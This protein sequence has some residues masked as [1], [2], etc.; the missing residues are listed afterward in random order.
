SR[1]IEWGERAIEL[2]CRLGNDEILAHALNNVG[3]ARTR[4]TG[5]AGWLEL[6]RS[7]Q[8]ALRCRFQEHVARAHTNLASF[9]IDNRDYRAGLPHLEAGLAFCSEYG[10]SVAEG[11]LRALRARLNFEQGAWSEAIEQAEQVLRRG[12]LSVAARISALTVVGRVRTRRGVDGALEPLGEAWALAMGAGE[13]RGIVTVAAARAEHGWLHGDY[14]SVADELRS[15]VE[16]ALRDP[17]H[18]R[19]GEF[20]FWACRARA[21]FDG[22]FVIPRPYQLQMSGACD[23][24]SRAWAELGCPYE[25]ALALSDSPESEPRKQ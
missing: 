7:L 2:A 12:G 6:E 22:T 24:A 25:Q 1:A 21:E 8:L 4:E 20:V 5:D 23:A 13:P 9:A 3:A 14:S 16:Y 10:L 17:Y 15:A 11:Y 19:V 18:W